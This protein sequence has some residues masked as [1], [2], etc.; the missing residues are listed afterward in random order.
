MEKLLEKISAIHPARAMDFDDL[1]K[2]LQKEVQAGYIMC[3]TDESLGLEIYKYSNSCTYD[4]HWNVFT[5]IA[6]GLILA[7]KEKQVVA[8]PFPKFFNYSEIT[9]YLPDEPFETF[10]KYDGSLAII[11][12]WKS[13]WRVATCLSLQSEQ[14]KWAE[15]WLHANINLG[16]V[17]VPGATY[18]AEIVYPGNRIVVPYDYEGLV[19]LGIYTSYGQ[20]MSYDTI[21]PLENHTKFRV[22]KRNSYESIDDILKISETLPSSQEGFVVRFKNGYRIKIKG[23][24][25][26]RIHRLISRCTPLAVWEAMRECDDLE[27]IKK[28]LPEEFAKDL[29]SMRVILNNLY[30]DFITKILKAELYTKDMSDQELGKAIQ[31][32]ELPFSREVTAY[33]FPC[34]KKNFWED[35]SKP[36]KMR[37]SVFDRFRPTANVLEGYIP[38]TS[39]NRFEE[40]I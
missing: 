10:T 27:T 11:Y 19:M 17:L 4:K 33:L 1:Q 21:A 34:R 14:S 13:K 31:S 20:E 5:L 36:S 23:E 22:A 7:P 40:N 28:E 9:T 37:R 26:C 12:F 29:D 2:G 35:V 16:A 32:G 39:M 18:L 30:N 6:R 24:E 3:K 38:C 15:K 8:T 25:Y